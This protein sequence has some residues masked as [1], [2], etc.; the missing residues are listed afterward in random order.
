MYAQAGLQVPCMH[1]SGA[2]EATLTSA[3]CEFKDGNNKSEMLINNTFASP[4]R[5]G[6]RER[7]GVIY[8]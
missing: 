6:E 4:K 1:S 5:Q 3:F 2:G 8:G 7:H